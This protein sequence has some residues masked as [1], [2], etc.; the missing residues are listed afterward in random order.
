MLEE[1]PIILESSELERCVSDSGWAGEVIRR[2]AR[3]A[4][5]PRR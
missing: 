4:L 2:R 5:I 3:P 1:N